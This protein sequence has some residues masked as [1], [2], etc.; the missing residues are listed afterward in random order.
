MMMT[1][2]DLMVDTES[3]ARLIDGFVDSLNYADYG[4]KVKDFQE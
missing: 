2:W 1:T 4:V 3:I